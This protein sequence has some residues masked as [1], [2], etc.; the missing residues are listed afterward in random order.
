MDG[1]AIAGH[2]PTRAR[3]NFL[4]FGAPQIEEEEISEVVACLRRRWIGTGPKVQEFERAFAAYKGSPHA[5]ALHSCTAA[6]HLSLLA[7]G[8]GPGDEVITTPMTFC[9]TVNAIIHAGARP[10]LADCDRT[11]MN[12]RAEEIAR[13]ITPRTRAILVVHFAGLCCDMEPILELARSRNLL[14]IEDCAHAIESEYRGRKAGTIGDAGCF[15]FYVTK[16]VVTGEGGMVIT[17]KE[18]LAAAV[19]ILGLHGMSK[20]AWSRF[21][22]DGYRHYEVT[23]AGFKYNMMDLQAVIGIAQLKRVEANWRRRREIWQVYQRDMSDLPCQLPPSDG[24]AEGRHAHHLYTPLV[25][26]ERLGKSRDWVLAALTAENIGVGV[27]YLPVHRHTYYQQ[28]FGWRWGDYP[29]AE[30]IGER[31]VSLPLSPA[32][33]DQDVADVTRAFRKVLGGG[34]GD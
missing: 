2:A 27:H 8:F 9:A 14:V 7:S 24:G 32:L 23:A 21:S 25:D 29:N 31:T 13:H 11:T 6:L 18:Q 28:R 30:W 3:N 34:R 4:V 12:I 22:D 20:D 10:V 16:N 26:I 17:R 5:V 1:L 19:R 33:S 15:S